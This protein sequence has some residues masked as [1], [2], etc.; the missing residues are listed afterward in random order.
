MPLVPLHGHEELRARLDAARRTGSLPQSL[1]LHGEA[2]IGKQRL[3]L[4]LAQSLLCAEDRSP[5]GHC[6]QCRYSFEL[7]HPDLVWVFPRPKLK[8]ADASIEDVQF[9]LKEAAQERVGNVGLYAP[10]DTSDAIFVV[11]SRMLVRMASITPAMARRKV[12]VVGEAEKMAPPVETAEAPAA[13][14][15]LKLLE[16]PPADTYLIL[17]SSAPGALLP[18]IRSR[19]VATRVAPIPDSALLDWMAEPPVREWLA[20]GHLPDSESERLRI[21]GGAPGRLLA[22]RETSTAADA[23][24]RLL[25]AA[26]S[27]DRAKAYRVSLAQGSSGARGAY[28]DVLEALT[29]VLHQRVR[30]AVE[31]NDERAARNAAR[32]VAVVEESKT[33][34]GGNV[35]PQLITVSLL[36]SLSHVLSHP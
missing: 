30:S 18:T 13:N 20:K 35:N 5:C 14:A 1:L 23:A 9:D 28:T 22:A 17:T 8:D 24:R 7:R 4:W 25:E 31:A 36:A 3:A 27:G 2:G 21:A 26:L 12:F 11:T 15:F 10:P 33:L 32:A 16:E 34:A 19:V 6:P 29:V